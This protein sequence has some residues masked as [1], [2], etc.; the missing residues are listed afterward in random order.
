MVGVLVVL[1]N[2]LKVICDVFNEVRDVGVKVV[3]FD[4]DMNFEC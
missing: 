3:I 2:D 1:V 4:F